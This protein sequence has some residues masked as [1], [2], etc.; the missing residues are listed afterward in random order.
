MSRPSAFLSVLA[1]VLCCSLWP[2]AASAQ[3]AAKPPQS[4]APAPLEAA[5]PSYPELQPDGT[6]VFRL[7]MP[8]AAKVELNLEGVKDAFPMSKGS[9]GAWSVTVPTLAPQYYSYTFNVDGTEVLDLHNV[10]IKTSFFSNQSIF[11]VPGQ[12]PRSWEHANVPHGVVHHH[13]YHSN[14]VDINSEYYVYTPPGFD[15]GSKQ[16]YPVLYL[17]HGYS[18]DPSAWTSMGK[19]NVIL[20]NLIAQ[21][22]ARPMIVVMPLGYGTMEVIARGW[23]TWK[24]PALI[25]RNYSRFSDA[26]FKEV[27]PLAKKQYPLSDKREEHAVAGLSMGGAESLLVGLN[28]LDDFAYVGGFSS[29]PLA[30]QNGFESSF[31]GITA[32]S[33]PDINAKLRLLWIA[34]G[35]EDGLFAPNQKFIA[36]LKEKGLQPTAIQTPGMHVW[37]L[38]RENLTNFA[39][40]LFQSR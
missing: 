32:Q 3:P 18:D 33:A 23:S 22:K 35:T 24:D 11:L 28:H 38:W 40:L 9:D 19:A 16:K 4:A 6:A 12:P 29:A 27:M 8:N 14:I 15:P 7:A 39:P 10:S 20:D 1:I 37:M 26:L 21:G 30:D 34:C 25:H 31:P 5:P 13:Y 2:A 17:L 36:W